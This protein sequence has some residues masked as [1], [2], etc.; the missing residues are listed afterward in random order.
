MTNYGSSSAIP[1]NGADSLGSSAV[2]ILRVQGG[3]REIAHSLRPDLGDSLSDP[4]PALEEIELHLTTQSVRN[5]S[6]SGHASVLEAFQPFLVEREQA[7]RPVK[8]IWKLH[9]LSVGSEA[10]RY[11]TSISVTLPF[12]LDYPPSP[13]SNIFPF[14]QKVSAS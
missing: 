12:H 1:S 9:E 4:F 2:R 11:G 8:I 13:Y 5:I 3:L 7:G 6:E 10:K 14:E